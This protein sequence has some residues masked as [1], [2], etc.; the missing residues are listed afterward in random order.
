MTTLPNEFPEMQEERFGLGSPKLMLWTISAYLLFVYKIGPRYMKNREPYKLKT[1][2][3]VY[4]AFQV[5]A[6]IYIVQQV[7][8]LTSSDIFDFTICT[9]YER[10]TPI[11]KRFEDVLSFTFWLKIVELTDTICFVLKKKQNQITPLHVFHHT[12]TMTLVYLGAVYHK[13]QSALFPIFVNSVIH[14]IMYSYYLLA[15]IYGPEF[16]KRLIVIKKSITTLQMIQFTL[17]LT[18][19]LVTWRYCKISFALTAY[20]LVIVTIIFYG[21]Y[22]FYKKSYQENNDT[23][24]KK[25]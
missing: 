16:M 13:G 17:I 19:T 11:R 10:N 23:K 24:I 2:I 3:S 1:F 14:I 25:K 5:L 22:D 4:N 8:I 7:W 18:H 20:F 12:V 21:F 15:N 6:C 9:L